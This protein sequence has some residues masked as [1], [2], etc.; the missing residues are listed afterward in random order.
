[1]SSALVRLGMLVTKKAG[2]LGLLAAR[3]LSYV[4]PEGCQRAALDVRASINIPQAQAQT[5]LKN[6]QRQTL[7]RGTVLILRYDCTALTAA[8]P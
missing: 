7:L 1:M 8:L 3:I 2:S 5:A 6:C 4:N